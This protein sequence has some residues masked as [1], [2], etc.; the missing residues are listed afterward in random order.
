MARLSIN[1]ESEQLKRPI[2][3]EVVVP[4]DHMIMKGLPI[5][6]KNRP[7]RTMYVLEGVTGNATGPL[8]YSSLMPLAEDYNLVVVCIGGENKWWT[9]QNSMHEN[10]AEMVTTDVVN[11][12]RRIFNL[13]DKRE[14]TF[15]AGF[16]M[17]GYG[18]FVNGFR[19]PE[20]FSR[21]I[22]L[23]PALNKTPILESVNEPGWD[24]YF[25]SDYESMFNSDAISKYADSNNDYEY[26][27]A[28]VAKETPELMPKIFIASGNEDPLFAGNEIYRDYLRKLGYEVDWLEIDGNHSW[29]TYNIGMEAGVKWLPIGQDYFVEN[30]PYYGRW[31]HI[32]GTNFAHWNTMYNVEAEEKKNK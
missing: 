15:I 11:F 2:N 24:L 9:E 8:N 31:A 6:E 17:G 14:D 25:K 18:A 4:A 5:P 20:L 26:L 7:Y 1:F 10:F 3:I 19:H 12:T 22:A 21:I 16:S 13:S 30:V 28:K 32:D 29:Y 27:A 23:D